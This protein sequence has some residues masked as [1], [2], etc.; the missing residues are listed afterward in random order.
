MIAFDGE[1]SRDVANR[2]DRFGYPV[3]A[4]GTTAL[5]TERSSRSD[6]TCV[7]AGDRFRPKGG[8][9]MRGALAR[10]QLIEAPAIVKSGS[11]GAPRLTARLGY[12][13]NSVGG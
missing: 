8:V 3:G 4:R 7:A 5:A 9:R 1:R 12:I 13:Q 11:P 10:I 6:P 2:D